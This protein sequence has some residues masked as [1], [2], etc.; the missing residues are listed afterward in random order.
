MRVQTIDTD[1]YAG[2]WGPTQKIKLPCI[3]CRIAAAGGGAALLWL[4]L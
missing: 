3:P 1:G 2:A 4:L